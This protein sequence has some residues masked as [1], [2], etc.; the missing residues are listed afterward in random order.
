MEKNEVYL[1]LQ[2]LNSANKSHY[3]YPV[4]FF[5]HFQLVQ[6]SCPVGNIKYKKEHLHAN[7][8]RYDLILFRIGEECL[9]FFLVMHM[10]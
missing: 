8:I 10:A 2:H 5:T 1:S 4:T 9:E 6:K 3:C 7:T